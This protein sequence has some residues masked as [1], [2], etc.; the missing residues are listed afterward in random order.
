MHHIISV[1]ASYPSVYCVHPRHN[2]SYLHLLHI[3]LPSPYPYARLD[4]RKKF[5]FKRVVM[6]WNRLSR[7]MVESLSHVVFEKRVPVTVSD[8]V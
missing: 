1:G 3:K 4:I 7:K 6:H 5:F 8:V 2:L